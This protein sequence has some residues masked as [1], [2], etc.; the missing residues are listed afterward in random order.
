MKFVETEHVLESHPETDEELESLR[1]QFPHLWPFQFV[2]E[3][4]R[5][6]AACRERYTGKHACELFIWIPALSGSET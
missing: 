5:T 1:E 6:C 3:A 4:I 2:C